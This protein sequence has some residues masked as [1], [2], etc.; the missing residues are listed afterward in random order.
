MK[1]LLLLFVITVITAIN[2]YSQ[3]IPKQI[4]YQGIL[5][6]AA[7]TIVPDGNYQLTFKIYNDPTGGTALWTE[8]Q[9]V[10]VTNGVFSAHLGS[11]VPI[12]TVPF[13]RIHFLGISIGLDPELSPRTTLTP[14]PYSFMTLDVMD[15]SITTSKIVN[16]TITGSDIAN[17]TIGPEKLNFTPGTGTIGG[18]GTANYL[19]VFTNA[20]TLGNSLIYQNGGNIGIGTTSPTAKFQLAGGDAL[21]NTLVIGLGG[22][23]VQYNT[24]LG[25]NTLVDNT[26]GSNNTAVG[27]ASLMTNTTGGGNSALGR[28]SLYMNSTTDYNSALGYSAGDYRVGIAGGTF[29]GALAY[30]NANDFANVAGYGYNCRP[31]ASNQVRIGNSSVTSIGGYAGW[32]NLSDARFKVAV[33]EN[34]KGLD[35]ILKLRPVTYQLDINKLA[36]T[37]NEDQFRD[38]DGNIINSPNAMDVKAR[39]EKSQMVFTGFVAQ[40]VEQVANEI[41]F[42]FSGIDKPKN[43]NDFYGL[44]YAEFV[45]PLVK[46]IQE[47]QK[48]IEDL[49]RRIEVLESK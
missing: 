10:A 28:F 42:E 40:E 34:V 4:S 48:I 27:R 18:S 29:I 12:T 33:S 17:N 14:T 31:T 49:T 37:L 13:N 19:P 23:Q 6:T 2:I 8:A 5:K 47:Q 1:K 3:A 11:I 21:I 7:G 15:N 9:T 26:T 36:Q 24:A 44:R 43:E 32:T 30:A 16:L 20:N 45:V 38:N 41:G 39:N 46:A 22:G 35:F 25:M